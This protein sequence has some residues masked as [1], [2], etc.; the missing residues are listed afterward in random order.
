[1]FKFA[2]AL[3][4][5]LKHQELQKDTPILVAVLDSVKIPRAV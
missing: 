3:I 5:G 1:M 2:P 4:K